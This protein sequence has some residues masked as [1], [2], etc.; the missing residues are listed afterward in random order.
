MPRHKSQAKDPD[1]LTPLQR[2]FVQEYLIDLNATAAYKRAGYKGRRGIEALASQILANPNVQAAIARQ[3]AL[4]RERFRLTRDN[5]IS[6]LLILAMSDLA[7][8]VE[9]GRD[10]E[11]QVYVRVKN[12]NEIDPHRRRAIQS[13]K[14][15]KKWGNTS[16]ETLELRREGKQEALKLL[17]QHLGLHREGGEDGEGENPLER[18][19]KSIEGLRR[20]SQ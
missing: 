8:F 15:V 19:V 2:R 6:E 4:D 16:E 5:I 9:W 7:D 3:Q 12:S 14:L 1:G 10:A 13:I 20:G 11:G 18:L 17:A